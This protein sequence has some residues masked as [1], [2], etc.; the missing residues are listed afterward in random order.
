MK[1]LAFLSSVLNVGAFLI[2]IMVSELYRNQIVVVLP[3][4]SYLS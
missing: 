3:W 1:L 4:Q 2:G